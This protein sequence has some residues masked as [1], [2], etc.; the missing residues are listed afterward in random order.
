MTALAMQPTPLN[1]PPQ[2]MLSCAIGWPERLWVFSAD[3][4]ATGRVLIDL[5][6]NA[7]VWHYPDRDLAR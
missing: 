7:A 2:R 4:T 3:S 6:L 5:L 1:V